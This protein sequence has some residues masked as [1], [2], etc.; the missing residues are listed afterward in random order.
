MVREDKYS[1]LGQSYN[2]SGFD[3]FKSDDYL[4]HKGS[5]LSS[6]EMSSAKKRDVYSYISSEDDGSSIVND[7]ARPKIPHRKKKM[8]GAV[9]KK[10]S[11]Q[12][13]I[14][15]KTRISTCVPHKKSKLRS[16]R[17]TTS[18][19]DAG[20]KRQSSP[21]LRSV[22]T[23]RYPGYSSGWSS[24]DSE[25]SKDNVISTQATNGDQK[26]KSDDQFSAPSSINSTVSTSSW[27]SSER[28]SQNGQAS[29]S[30]MDIQL[31]PG[32]SVDSQEHK[33]DSIGSNH[34]NDPGVKERESLAN[35][36]SALNEQ[37]TSANIVSGLNEQESSADIIS[38][39]DRQESPSKVVY[40]QE[41][42]PS[43]SEGN[44]SSV[45][46]TCGVEDIPDTHES[47]PFAPDSVDL[48]MESQIQN[49]TRE[50]QHLE[51]QVALHLEVTV[52][53]ETQ[54]SLTDGTSTE[55]LVQCPG[56]PVI[57]LQNKDPDLLSP[58]G[59]P[60]AVSSARTKTSGVHTSLSDVDSYVLQSVVSDTSEDQ[61]KDHERTKLLRKPKHSTH[62]DIQSD[63]GDSSSTAE[64][65]GGHSCVRRRKA[66]LFS[67]MF[68]TSH[69]NKHPYRR[70]SSR[71][72]LE[73][74]IG[75]PRSD[76]EFVHPS[77]HQL[78]GAL[79]T[80][81]RR[82]HLKLRK[83]RDSAVS[84]SESDNQKNQQKEIAANEEQSI[85]S[86]GKT[87]LQVKTKQ[88]PSETDSG[89][90]STNLSEI[91]QSS[92]T[93][94]NQ[95]NIESHVMTK[96]S[97]SKKRV[98]REVINISSDSESA[99]FEPPPF[100][101]RKPRPN[102]SKP[103]PSLIDDVYSSAEKSSATKL[104]VGN[105]VTTGAEKRTPSILCT[106][107]VSCD[108]EIPGE[109]TEQPL[110][111]KCMYLNSS[112]TTVA[113]ENA[114]DEHASHAM[115][116]ENVGQLNSS[117]QNLEC[118][119]ERELSK[120]KEGLNDGDKSESSD[121]STSDRDK[122]IKSIDS[123]ELVATK[124]LDNDMP[125]RLENDKEKECTS[126]DKLS[127]AD[128]SVSSSSNDSIDET[129]F[130]RPIGE[131]ATT[132][133]QSNEGSK[134]VKDRP[135]S[136]LSKQKETMNKV[137]GVTSPE[138]Q[139][140]RKIM[141]LPPAGGAPDESEEDSSDLE[142]DADSQGT[143]VL[144]QQPLG[145]DTKE[146]AREIS[147]MSL[148]SSPRTSSQQKTS[149]SYKTSLH[150]PPR[151]LFSKSTLKKNYSQQHSEFKNP[152]LKSQ[153]NLQSQSSTGK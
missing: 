68:G 76:S 132:R 62:T 4:M 32:H 6:A 3:E 60:R 151:F 69:L 140:V 148:R 123:I 55:P 141:S 114:T 150:R 122:G 2:T 121:L 142:S 100:K 51:G 31:E 101:K 37:E 79:I 117:E 50:S 11:I 42:L 22:A 91:A 136:S 80:C 54:E 1:V 94:D 135:S 116:H 127:V 81:R 139:L 47:T 58:L 65:G 70:A 109:S 96:K 40:R 104:N 77:P 74:C 118:T 18:R 106:P 90:S 133:S 102:Y 24:S 138:Q 84:K 134:V 8:E 33:G 83:V 17:S 45:P 56:S 71:T 87:L 46:S 152:P 86:E 53:P 108:L 28:E 103:K 21:V 115:Q 119:M 26:E 97:K 105:L 143:A 107:N 9:P 16:G 120:K 43:V 95:Q 153:G 52:I 92:N 147:G 145:V 137:K 63:I 36:V 146:Q 23:L 67:R 34:H 110:I 25:T 29:N 93:S 72:N 128:R 82:K 12:S 113:E 125:Q 20:N 15:N 48:E 149:Q 75:V 130:Q 98:S 129:K 88:K 57:P 89:V 7:N 14:E 38:D 78:T 144:T 73:S 85:Y 30:V 41:P 124:D 39:L 5:S 13:R 64:S 126:V 44:I 61:T 59:V 111:D 66:K 27:T 131:A 19:E 35:I 99:A 10:C 49:D 112:D